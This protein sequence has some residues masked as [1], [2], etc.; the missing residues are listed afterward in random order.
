[1]SLHKPCHLGAFLG[2]LTAI[3]RIIHFESISALLFSK[4]NYTEFSYTLYHSN[5]GYLKE[6]MGRLWEHDL[7]PAN[8]GV[9]GS[10]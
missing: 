1:M 6:Q 7:A 9:S 5:K 3:W 10:A 2:D 8:H 4:R